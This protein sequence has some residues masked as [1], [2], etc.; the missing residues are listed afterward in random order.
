[1]YDDVLKLLRHTH[2]PATGPIVGATDDEIQSIETKVGLP[3]PDSLKSWL[4]VCKSSTG[5]EGGIYGLSETHEFLNIDALLNLY[6]TWRA[7]GWI[8]VAGDGCGNEYVI[9]QHDGREVVAFVEAVVEEDE[10]AYITATSLEIF[11][12]EMLLNEAGQTGWPFDRDY[13]QRVDP[14]LLE[15]SPNPFDVD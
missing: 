6:P 9:V 13:V 1:M 8:P 14:D 7:L 2:N 4:R 5:G 12:R 3:L 15:I 10:I 11:L